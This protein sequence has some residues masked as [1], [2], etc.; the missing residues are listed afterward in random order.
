MIRIQS[1]NDPSTFVNDTIIYSGITCNGS[2]NRV[3]ELWLK[4]HAKVHVAFALKNRRNLSQVPNVTAI[5]YDIIF[6][7]SMDVRKRKLDRNPEL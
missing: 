2:I 3:G 6:V 5:F 7:D 4:K 1:A